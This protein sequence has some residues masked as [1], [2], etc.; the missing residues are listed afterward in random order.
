MAA[1]Q[2]ILEEK[3]FEID[4]LRAQ[5]EAVGHMDRPQLEDGVMQI[6][7]VRNEL[8]ACKHRRF[9]AEQRMKDAK[10]EIGNLKRRI[11]VLEKENGRVMAVSG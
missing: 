8:K 1:Q 6:A 7:N 5:V 4:T 2:G 11:K 10:I 9:E 3:V